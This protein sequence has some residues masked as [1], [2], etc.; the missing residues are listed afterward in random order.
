[1]SVA[2]PVVEAPKELEDVKSLLGAAIKY[3]IATVM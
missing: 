1:M 2:N 3:D